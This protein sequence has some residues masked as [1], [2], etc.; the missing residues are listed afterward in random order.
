[1]NA[2]PAHLTPCVLHS[3]R[4]VNISFD[5]LMSTDRM[6]VIFGIWKLCNMVGNDSTKL[7]K[8]FMMGRN[9]PKLQKCVGHLYWARQPNIFLINAF[10]YI[11]I[12]IHD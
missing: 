4:S 3:C 5:L 2:G 6:Q 8:I 11:M 10:R 12:N 1:M 9:V 7:S